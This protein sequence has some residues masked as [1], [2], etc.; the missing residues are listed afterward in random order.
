[1]NLLGPPP[2]VDAAVAERIKAW[3]REL[4]AVPA[5]ASVRVAQLACREPGC[6]PLET[7]VLVSVADAPTVHH[8]FHKPAADVTRA[9][10]QGAR[11]HG[12]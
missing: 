5:D 9:D 3:A 7:V 11:D 6:P 12:H 4:F 10:L 2:R 8:K 1:V